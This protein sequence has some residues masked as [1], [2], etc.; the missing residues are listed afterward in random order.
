MS[1]I[2]VWPL[3]LEP[4]PA[5]IL[6]G[7]TKQD[8]ARA[9]FIILLPL[10]GSCYTASEVV[11]RALPLQSQLETYRYHYRALYDLANDKGITTEPDN[12]DGHGRLLAGKRKGHKQRPRWRAESWREIIS[13]E[14]WA[15]CVAF[16]FD[17]QTRAASHFLL[18][19]RRKRYYCDL[20]S[21]EILEEPAAADQQPE[22]LADLGP[23]WDEARADTIAAG[24][25]LATWPLMDPEAYA[26][27]CEAKKAVFLQQYE[28]W[29]AVAKVKKPPAPKKQG[30]N[31]ELITGRPPRR[32][33]RALALAAAVM[34]AVICWPPSRQVEPGDRNPQDPVF[35]DMVI[36]K[37]FELDLDAYIKANREPRPIFSTSRPSFPNS[38]ASTWREDVPNTMDMLAQSQPPPMFL[39]GEEIF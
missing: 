2:E 8:K 27:A 13:D 23:C 20:E 32:I 16:M 29:K 17:I 18:H 30:E 19:G 21:F 10:D 26:A 38:W 31:R 34:L 3:T 6:T 4:R 12:V 28:A 25:S 22:A 39:A 5:F 9:L 33:A 15:W 24:P 7:G 14:I 35:E 37:D 1:R 36:H 11:K